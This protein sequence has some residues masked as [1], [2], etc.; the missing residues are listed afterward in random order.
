MTT[1]LRLHDQVLREL[2]VHNR[3]GRKIQVLIASQSSSSCSRTAAG[4]AAN[5]HSLAA[6]GEP[7]NKHSQPCTAADHGCGALALA[8]LVLGEVTRLQWV[9]RAIQRQRCQSKLQ[10]LCAL[11]MTTLFGCVDYAADRRQLG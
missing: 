2:E 4:Q 9:F 7:A 1:W 5:Q 10:L 11:K 3:L 6:A 8:F